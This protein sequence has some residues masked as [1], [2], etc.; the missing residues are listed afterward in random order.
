MAAAFRA[1]FFFFISGDQFSPSLH[2]SSLVLVTEREQR[3]QTP[4]CSTALDLNVSSEINSQ[5][6]APS[7]LLFYPES[8]EELGLAFLHSYS[9]NWN[10]DL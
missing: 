2:F 6:S 4:A 5:L 1:V 9:A 10:Q 3:A 7:F 8:G